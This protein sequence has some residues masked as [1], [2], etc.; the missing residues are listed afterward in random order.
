M[1]QAIS[2]ATGLIVVCATLWF[3]NAEC[4]LHDYLRRAAGLRSTHQV[5]LG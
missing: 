2:V 1:K 4:W 5:Y 3:A